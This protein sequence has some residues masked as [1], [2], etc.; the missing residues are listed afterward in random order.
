MVH[1]EGTWFCRI[2]TGYRQR[3]SERGGSSGR[4]GSIARGSSGDG[5]PD[6]S[7]SARLFNFCCGL[8]QRT[9]GRTRHGQCVDRGGGRWA[10]AVANQSSRQSRL[11]VGLLYSGTF[12]ASVNI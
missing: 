4:N 8:F 2:I 7:T 3:T 1:K 5:L 11:G 6:F 9:V 12:S 10:R